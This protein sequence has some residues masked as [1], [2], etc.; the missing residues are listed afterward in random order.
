MPLNVSL[1]CFYNEAKQFQFL[2]PTRYVSNNGHVH[3]QAYN[4]MQ[5]IIA[6]YVRRI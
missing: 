1:V 5:R 3:T 4:I 6:F 2:T